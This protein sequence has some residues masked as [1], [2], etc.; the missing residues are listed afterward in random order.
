MALYILIAVQFVPETPRF[1]LS[2]G[3]EQE[4]FQFLVD[5]HGNGDPNDE[6][7][8]FEFD[9]MKT[10][11]QREQAAKAEKWSTI[12]K[13]RAN[14]HRM[15]LAMLMTFMTNVSGCPYLACG[16]LLIVVPVIWM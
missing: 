3:R 6:L 11:I 14:R 15:G 7:V 13:S 16:A 2:K 1:L 4:A 10:A 8:L 9:E 5:Y 12:L